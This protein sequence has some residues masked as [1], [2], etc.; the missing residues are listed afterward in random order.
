MR[1]PSHCCLAQAVAQ[2]RLTLLPQTAPRAN[3]YPWRAQVALPRVLMVGTPSRTLVG[4]PYVPTAEVVVV[5]EEHVR[6]AKVIIFKKR[7]RKNSRRNAGHRQV[8][9]ARRM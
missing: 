1:K 5:V 9:F 2:P 3:A 4:R 6:D 8:S 7:R